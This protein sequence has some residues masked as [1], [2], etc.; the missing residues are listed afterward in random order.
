VAKLNLGL[1]SADVTSRSRDGVAHCT[2][3][4]D[5]TWQVTS[6]ASNDITYDPI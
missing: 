1:Q 4:T 3:L 2:H 6:L 5:E